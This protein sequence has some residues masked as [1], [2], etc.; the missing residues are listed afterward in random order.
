VGA[1]LDWEGN[2]SYRSESWAEKAGLEGDYHSGGKVIANCTMGA[3]W[4][5]RADFSD[6]NSWGGGMGLLADFHGND[7]YSAG[8][9]AIG[10]GYWLGMGFLYDGEG[11]DTYESCYFTQGSSAHFA[12]GFILDEGGNDHMKLWGDESKRGW[13]W[14]GAGLGFGWDFS[15]GMVVNVG[16]DDTYE[17]KKISLGCAEVRSFGMFLDVGGN[18]TYIFPEDGLGL[19]GADSRSYSR[20]YYCYEENVGLFID[21]LGKDS[22]FYRKDGKLEPSNERKD[23]GI[24][25]SPKKYKSFVKEESRGVGADIND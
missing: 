11:D 5:R 25:F 19:G 14:G 8:N 15:V 23:G 6:G 17:A 18:D 7:T 2:D 22:Y 16:G 13:G 9:W 20:P 12:I 21:Y 1:L 3:G 24:W 10:V 4:G